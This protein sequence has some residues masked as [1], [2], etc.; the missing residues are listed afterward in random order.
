MEITYKKV[1]HNDLFLN[2][3]DENL[4]NMEQCLNYIPIYNRFFNLNQNN[5]NNI[6]LNN[7]NSLKMIEKKISE[8]IF[9]G[10][11]IKEF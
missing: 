6:S 1:N 11:I 3:E 10:E 5:Y 2:F 9:E 4:L 8:N 7:Q